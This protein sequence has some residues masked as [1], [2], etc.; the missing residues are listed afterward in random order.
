M[1]YLIILYQQPVP[2]WQCRYALKHRARCY[3]AIHKEHLIEGFHI[4]PSFHIAAGENGLALRSKIDLLIL[5]CIE[6]VTYPQAVPC[7][8]ETA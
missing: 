1:G 8:K 3:R 2:G 4:E 7:C 5:H 6:Q